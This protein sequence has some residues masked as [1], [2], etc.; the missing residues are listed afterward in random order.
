M[1]FIAIN[2]LTKNKTLDRKVMTELKGGSSI[3]HKLAA[4]SHLSAQTASADLGD[5]AGSETEPPAKTTRYQIGTSA[6]SSP[7]YLRFF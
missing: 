7:R 3:L 4:I 5:L 2:D 6:L 1:S